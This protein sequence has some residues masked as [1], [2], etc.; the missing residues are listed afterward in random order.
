[1]ANSGYRNG[2]HAEF[3][4]DLNERGAVS[5]KPPFD[6]IMQFEIDFQRPYLVAEVIRVKYEPIEELIKDA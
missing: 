2:A 3:F 5:T 1:L 4:G 6:S